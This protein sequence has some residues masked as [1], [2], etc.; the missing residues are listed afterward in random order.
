MYPAEVYSDEEITPTGIV[1]S[2]NPAHP[3]SFWRGWNF[4]VDLY[5]I[6]EH[7][8]TRLRARNHTFDAGNQI[9]A[10][11]SEGRVGSGTE[12]KPGDL[13]VLV[14]RLYRALPPELRATS[15][16]T[17]DVEKDRYGFQG[18][19][20]QVQKKPILTRETAA[21]ILVT[22]QTMK[23][24]VA[25]MAEWSVEQR[26]SIAGELL[27]AFATVPRAYIQAISTPLV[28]HHAVPLSQVLTLGIASSSCWCWSSTC[29]YH[30][31]TPFSRCLFA[32]SHRTP[33]H[34]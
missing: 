21:N 7:A 28:G 1:K 16:M 4:V 8:V 17:G 22:M 12:L 27:D 6:L 15:E 24:V 2:V 26:C 34:G 30:S 11:F 19:S 31:L 23:M 33:L 20:S 18:E 9:A 32:R 25:G 10:L 3:V 5:R 13:L 14:E 29:F